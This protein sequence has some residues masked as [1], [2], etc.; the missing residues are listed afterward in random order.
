MLSGLRERE[1]PGG[2]VGFVVEHGAT[3]VPGLTT[4]LVEEIWRRNPSYAAGPVSR[5][6]LHASCH[7]NISRVLEL[8]TVG[9]VGEDGESA[10]PLY[11]A[12]RATGR[13]RAEQRVP[14][15]DVLRSFRLGGRLIWGELIAQAGERGALDSPGMTEVGSRLW[16]VVDDTSAQVAASYHLA[17]RVRLRA[18]EQRRGALWE[19]LLTGSEEGSVAAARALGLTAAGAYVVVV[20]ADALTEGVDAFPATVAHEALARRRCA[21]TW[22]HRGGTCV[23]VV[24]LPEDVSGDPARLVVDILRATTP[25][26]AGV[27]PATSVAGLV[28]A[29]RLAGLALASARTEGLGAVTL[30]ERLPEALLL[31]SPEL[32]ERLVSTVLGGVL[33]RPDAERVTLLETLEAWIASAG[34]VTR[35]GELLHCHRNTVLNRLRRL[36]ELTGRDD[37]REGRVPSE[38]DLAVRALALRD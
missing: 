24:V 36:R 18:D 19:D 37:L 14:L 25:L 5:E 26:A 33:A 9:L 2:L 8:L 22:Q 13:L 10:D 7:D 20:A 30:D 38:I 15:D 31:R 12:A 6:D 17:E 21:S 34:S 35:T 3:L 4:Q 11:D 29:H 23:G 32:V 1:A 16:E 27:V 28:E